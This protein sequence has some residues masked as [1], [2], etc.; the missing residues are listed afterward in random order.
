MIVDSIVL[1]VA[2][3]SRNVRR[4]A[5]AEQRSLG[6]AW[7][8]QDVGTLSATRRHDMTVERLSY[9]AGNIT[10][11]GTRVAAF[12]QA[13]KQQLVAYATAEQE[14]AM[15]LATAEKEFELAPATG[16]TRPDATTCGG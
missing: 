13:D 1:N 3:L 2:A 14:Y 5:E 9:S 7:F 8:L 4:L 16:T 15:A 6:N 11:S 12:S 10:R